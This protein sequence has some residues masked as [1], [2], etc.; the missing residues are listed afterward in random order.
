MKKLIYLGICFLLLSATNS[1]VPQNTVPTAKTERL[2][3][4]GEFTFMAQRAD[5]FGAEVQ[6]ILTSLPGGANTRVLD[7]DYGYSLSVKKNEIVSVL[8][9]FGR[10]YSADM[11]PDR[12]GYRFTSKDFDISQAPG[13]DNSTV[14]TIIPKDQAANPRLSLQIFPSGKGYLNISSNDR[15]P[16][17]YSGYIDDLKTK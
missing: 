17:S 2:L 4:A 6:T 12:N 15:Q 13:R 5:P 1:C 7:L 10:A 3:Q 16:I 8:P 9:Y 14:Y 11:N